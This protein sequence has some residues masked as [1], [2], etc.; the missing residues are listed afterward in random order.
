[1]TCFGRCSTRRNLCST[2]EQMIFRRLHFRINVLTVVLCAFGADAADK[3]T[4]Q[5]NILPLIQANCAK[6]HNED[7]KK[8]DLDL[9]SYQGTLKG[10]GSGAVVVSGNLDSSKLWKA[11]TQTED[12]TMPPNQPPLADKDLDVFKNWIQGGLL[13]NVGGKA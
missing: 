3:V 4:Y 10:S 7:K 11:I 1:M 12:P 13:E 6:C 2:I 5:D 9:T 8:A